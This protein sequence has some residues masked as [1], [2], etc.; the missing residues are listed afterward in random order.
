VGVLRVQVEVAED[1]RAIPQGVDRM[2]RPASPG[3]RAVDSLELVREGV[4]FM[5]EGDPLP[6]DL[7]PVREL[8][9]SGALSD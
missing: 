5:G 8:V 9:R 4:P 2:R 7:E 6:A 3:D 1:E